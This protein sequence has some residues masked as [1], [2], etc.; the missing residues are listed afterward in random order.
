MKSRRTGRTCTWAGSLTEPEI[1]SDHSPRFN[2]QAG[3]W[4]Q[5]KVPGAGKDGRYDCVAECRG[6]FHF[7][8]PRIEI[9]QR[10]RTMWQIGHSTGQFR[11][12]YET[13]SQSRRNGV[14]QAG[15]SY[16]RAE[17]LNAEEIE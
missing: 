17:L 11:F 13:G 10:E 9:A 12:C 2:K 6:G 5:K 14:Y 16:A 3:Q 7:G 8:V 15:M 1:T 4:R